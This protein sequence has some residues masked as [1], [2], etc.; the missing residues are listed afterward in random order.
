MHKRYLLL[1]PTVFIV[2]TA[3]FFL[4][5]PQQKA[6]PVLVSPASEVTTSQAPISAQS[7]APS[8][9]ALAPDIV[10]PGENIEQLLNS[11]SLRAWDIRADEQGHIKKITGGLMSFSGKNLVDASQQFFSQYGKRLFGLNPKALALRQVNENAFPKAI[12]YQQTING[13]PVYQ[14]RIA[15]FFDADMNLIHA[16]SDQ[17]SIDDKHDTSPGVS[18]MQAA[19][20]ALASLQISTHGQGL[21]NISAASLASSSEYFVFKDGESLANAYRFVVSLGEPLY[22]E[23]EVFVD[24][25]NAKIIRDRVL[26]RK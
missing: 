21:Q 11:A 20:S 7:R 26:S 10:S 23:R 2:A 25:A 18:A 12:I 24:A 9:K 22:E 13:I 14:S 1:I 8:S 19:Q 5:S 15:L 3:G 4:F 6:S 17:T 16:S